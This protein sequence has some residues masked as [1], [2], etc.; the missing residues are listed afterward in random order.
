MKTSPK[1]E[2]PP[3]IKQSN[4]QGAPQ[5]FHNP[6]RH[7][8]Q[9]PQPQQPWKEP[10]NE[11]NEKNEKK[12]PQQK[13]RQR[14]EQKGEREVTQKVKQEVKQEAGPF[15]LPRRTLQPSDRSR[16]PG[17]ATLSESIAA[18]SIGGGTSPASC[19]RP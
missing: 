19:L 14:K 16:S 7:K 17:A 11:K 2:S 13:E 6:P 15:A 4:V 3:P 10:Q 5:G 1:S 9:Q 18:S 8:Q 12:H